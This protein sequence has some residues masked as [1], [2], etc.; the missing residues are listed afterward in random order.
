MGMLDFL[1]RMDRSVRHCAEVLT[2]VVES[3]EFVCKSLYWELRG[4]LSN[5][6]LLWEFH[7]IC[8]LLAGLS[9]GALDGEGSCGRKAFRAT[10]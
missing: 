8:W 7:L 4:L 9:N 6:G 1:V 2:E 10:R 3:S 5:I